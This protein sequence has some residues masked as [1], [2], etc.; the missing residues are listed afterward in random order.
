VI[1]TPTAAGT[2]TANLHV[3]DNSGNVGS[4]QSV[5]LTG[6]GSSGTPSVVKSDAELSPE[7][8]T[9]QAQE[10][11][12]ASTEQIITLSNSG[13]VAL[14]I[15]GIAITGKDAD[16]FVQTN[17]CGRSVAAASSCIISLKF[18]PKG[19]GTRTAS[20]IVV[21]NAGVTSESVRSA[22]LTGVGTTTRVPGL[23]SGSPQGGKDEPKPFGKTRN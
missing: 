5:T 12:V 16:D 14:P 21:N 19:A 7:G 23:A 6:T 17:N 8:L 1:F 20:V 22:K 10:T 9:F 11:G 4:T 15:Q 18:V 3:V 13:T 2:R